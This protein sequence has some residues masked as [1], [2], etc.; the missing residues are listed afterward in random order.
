MLNIFIKGRKIFHEKTSE[1]YN[2]KDTHLKLEHSL[3]SVSKWEE[4]YHKPFLSKDKKTIEETIDYIRCMTLNNNVDDNV[5]D[6]LSDNDINRIIEYIDENRTATIIYD[7]SPNRKKSKKIITS[8]WIYYEMIMFHIPPEYQKWH[9][10]RL[11]ALIEICDA[12][13]SPSKKMT[14]QETLA[15]YNKLNKQRK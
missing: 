5:Y 3:I 10:S 4:K 1:F 8:E 12:E 9:L 15:Y 14:E 2:I 6:L 11:M 13:N 7:L